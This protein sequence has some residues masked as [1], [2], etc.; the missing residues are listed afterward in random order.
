MCYAHYVIAY[1][2]KLITSGQL[3]NEATKK[4]AKEKN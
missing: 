4:K 2:E 1:L 3:L